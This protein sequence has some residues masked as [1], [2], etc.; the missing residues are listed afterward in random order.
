MSPALNPAPRI[1]TIFV[2][3]RR[4][5]SSGDTGRLFD[6]LNERLPGRVFRDLNMPAGVD[7]GKLIHEEVGSCV[8]LI[9]VIGPEWLTLKDAAGR[10]RLDDPHD[11]VREEIAKALAREI[12]VIP[13]LVEDASMPR[14]EDLP[15]DLTK[16]SERNAIALSDTRWAFDV[17]RLLKMIGKAVPELGALAE[18]TRKR[19]QPWLE[20]FRNV[21]GPGIAAFVG[22]LPFL[23]ASLLPFQMRKLIIPVS[24]FVMGL[25]AAVVESYRTEEFSPSALSRRFTYSLIALVIGLVALLV[26]RETSTTTVEVGSHEV[27]AL[28]GRSFDADPSRPATCPC[29]K[30]YT[31]E[32]CLRGNLDKTTVEQC[33]GPLKNERLRFWAAYL[34]LSAGFGGL[35]GLAG[36]RRK[37]IDRR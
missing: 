12:L 30:S 3:Y 36:M 33:W 21:R 23:D 31:D 6:D 20:F 18:A 35:M 9:A 7:F 11:F 8:V 14:A 1:A 5:D 10:R 17:E 25:A 34:T 26:G 29:P 2:N 32:D 37:S 4:A 13:V 22:L 24:A 27:A 28:V 19:R 16:L 15:P